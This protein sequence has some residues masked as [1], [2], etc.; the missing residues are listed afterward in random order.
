MAD[1]TLPELWALDMAAK[2]V[3]PC[4]G[5]EQA[6]SQCT[7]GTTLDSI[8]AHARTLEALARHDPSIMPVDEDLLIARKAAR[9]IYGQEA[10][11]FDVSWNRGIHDDSIAVAASRAALA[12]FR[13]EKGL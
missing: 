5:W 7:S 10:P 9:P 2:M 12:A 8:I 11:E 3:P 13:K 4:E 6:K 1:E